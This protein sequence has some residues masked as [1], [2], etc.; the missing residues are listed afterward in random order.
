MEVVFLQK[1]YGELSLGRFEEILKGLCK[2]LTVVLTNLTVV[3]NGWVKA[4]VSGEDEKAAIHFLDRKVGLAPIAAGNVQRFSILRGRIVFSGQSKTQVF[5]DVGVFSPYIVYATIPLQ[6]LQGQLVDGK[7]IALERIVELFGLVN[8]FPLEIRVVKAGKDMFEAELTEK[9][10]EFYGTWV[11][12]RVDRLIV[13]GAVGERVKKAIRK[14]RLIRDVV[15]VKQLDISEH[16][17]V[18]KL[19]TDAKGLVPKL[20]VWLP[21]VGF[22]CFSPRK[23]L[24]LANGRW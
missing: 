8:G 6:R 13:L 19:G 7:K 9:Q 21:K 4:A 15:R 2:D 11:D 3:E 5:V 14:A 12:S 22:A 23:I 18:C 16:V 1:I 24:E 20:G 17:L 10:L